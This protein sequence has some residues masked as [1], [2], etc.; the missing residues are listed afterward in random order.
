MQIVKRLHEKFRSSMNWITSDNSLAHLERA[1]I[2]SMNSIR[3][4][5]INDYYQ[6]WFILNCVVSACKSIISQNFSS[7]FFSSTLLFSASSSRLFNSSLISS[8]IANKNMHDPMKVVIEAAI[9]PNITKAPNNWKQKAIE[10]PN[11]NDLQSKGNLF[12]K[13]IRLKYWL[14]GFVLAYQNEN[15][16]RI[17]SSSKVPAKYA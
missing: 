1:I 2:V 4:K 9:V 10:Y 13:K 16:M 11:G 14:F 7:S 17:F 5:I 12:A 6:L 15:A 3:N 8:V